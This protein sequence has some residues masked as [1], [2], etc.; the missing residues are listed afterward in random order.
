MMIFLRY[1][2]EFLYSIPLIFIFCI[3]SCSTKSFLGEQ[4][5]AVKSEIKALSRVDHIDTFSEVIPYPKTENIIYSFLNDT[6]RL[7]VDSKGNYWSGGQASV[8]EWI[9]ADKTYQIFTVADGLPDNPISAMAVDRDDHIWIGTNNGEIAHLVGNEWITLKDTF[10]QIITSL[11]IA[12]DNHLWIGTNSGVY[13][14]SITRKILF[15]KDS[16]LPDSFI[17]SLEI[18]S[19]GMV[20]AGTVSGVSSFDG[21]TW[22]S[23]ILNQGSLVNCIAEAPNHTIWFGVDNQLFSFDG[24]KWKVYK[25]ETGTGLGFIMSISFNDS[26]DLFFIDSKGNF[27]QFTQTQKIEKIFN[28]PGAAE[29]FRLS[30]NEFIIGSHNQGLYHINNGSVNQIKSEDSLNG[31]IISSILVNN[32]GTIWIGTNQGLSLFDGNKWSYIKKDD[33]LISNSVLS[34]QSSSDGSIWVQTEKGISHFENDKWTNYP[35]GLDPMNRYT[36]NMIV[37]PD[38]SVWVMTYSGLTQFDGTTWKTI[39]SPLTFPLTWEPILRKTLYSDAN[40]NIWVGSDK[41]KLYR[42][43][44]QHWTQLSIP[45]HD[46]ITSIAVSNQDEIWIGTTHSG[47]FYK[48]QQDWKEYHPVP[49]RP[50]DRINSIYMDNSD[51]IWVGS[52][53][54]LICIRNDGEVCTNPDN[55][56]LNNKDVQQVVIDKNDHMWVSIYV[57]NIINIPIVH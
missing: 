20:W 16:G 15:S 24:T 54:G 42:Y 3:S 53:T 38:D 52:Q 11:K 22:N 12:P 44:G 43:D 39:D 25:F 8:V 56:L 57:Q 36:S 26:G 55:N 18:T 13:D 6:T 31:K 23:H 37:S 10:S 1:R 40:N 19:A 28:L 51:N 33:G 35:I 34:I 4:P 17:Q 29:A 27:V 47:I 21:K 14:Y 46:V 32:S 7:V 48:S 49:D 45:I 41:G 30:N 9:S 2:Y 5:L 50:V